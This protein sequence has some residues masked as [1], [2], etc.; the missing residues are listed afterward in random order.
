MAS[1]NNETDLVNTALSH[2]G[3]GSIRSLEQDSS[4]AAE[5]ARRLYPQA[6]DA[7]LESHPW[8]F[9]QKIAQLVES[10]ET[11]LFGYAHA[12][13]LPQDFLDIV[14]FDTGDNCPP[15]RH[16]ISGRL[17]YADQGAPFYLRYTVREPNVTRFSP[18]F[19][20]ALA[21]RLAADLVG[22]LANGK[23]SMWQRLNA[24]GQNAYTAA[25]FQDAGK[26][27]DDDSNPDYTRDSALVDSR[28]RHHHHR[29]VPYWYGTSIS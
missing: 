12:Y 27:E 1:A 22:P 10:G 3:K 20:R 2:L 28:Y 19:F 8:G 16:R 15:P 9:A 13:E 18:L 6:R 21:L 14:G 29:H 17:L 11:P 4:N 7:M 24:Q 25:V 26:Q 23:A 5:H